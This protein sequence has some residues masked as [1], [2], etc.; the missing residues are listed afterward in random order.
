MTLPPRPPEQIA[1]TVE[2][3]LEDEA[4]ALR[5]ERVA[6]EIAVVG[7]VVDVDA[8]VAVGED[9]VAHVEVADKRLRGI[10]VVAVTELTVEQQAVVEQTATE[11]SLIFSVVPSLVAR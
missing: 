1:E 6:G 7:L 10:G 8:E 3:L 5:I 4:D 2:V 9:E 11:Q